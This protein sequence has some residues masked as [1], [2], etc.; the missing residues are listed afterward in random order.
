MFAKEAP[1]IVGAALN[2]Y[3]FMYVTEQAIVEIDT[4]NFKVVSRLSIDT[5]TN[6]LSLA[7]SF[8]G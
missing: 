3:T 2:D 1:G 8:D 4:R 5:I 7:Y 6:P